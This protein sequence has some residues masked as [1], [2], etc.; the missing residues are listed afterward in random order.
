[1]SFPPAA[2]GVLVFTT[3]TRAPPPRGTDANINR[4]QPG[5]RSQVD[6]LEAERKCLRARSTAARLTLHHSNA[7]LRTAHLLAGG[8]SAGAQ[9]PDE[10]DMTHHLRELEAVLEGCGS[11]P[12]ERLLLASLDGP[13][14]IPPDE[15]LQW[16]P[17]AAARAAAAADTS[18]AGSL[19]RIRT[20]V[21]KSGPPLRCAVRP[22]RLILVAV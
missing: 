20:Y 22:W 7:L 5:S 3:R 13:D 16:S 6:E 17:E 2:P 1:M 8:G 21:E 18:T 14:P 9:R 10:Y 12:A 4:S 19:A 11:S 15:A